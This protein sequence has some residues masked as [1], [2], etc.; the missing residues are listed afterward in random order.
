MRPGLREAKRLD[1]RLEVL[2][3]GDADTSRGGIVED[4][5]EGR[6]GP[7][8]LRRDGDQPLCLCPTSRSVVFVLP[9]HRGRL[10]MAGESTGCGVF[11]AV[12][13]GDGAVRVVLGMLDC[14]DFRLDD[15][16]GSPETRRP[17]D[18]RAVEPTELP[19]RLEDPNGA[20]DLFAGV[21]MTDDAGELPGVSTRLPVA[22]LSIVTTVEME[23]RRCCVLK[24]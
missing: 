17:V 22:G 15:S 4:G 10:S 12:G 16:C 18:V 20:V 21:I 6:G 14:L 13:V 11:R 3:T 5:R 23:S 2:G 8:D 19:R 24:S 7:E 9:F 1:R